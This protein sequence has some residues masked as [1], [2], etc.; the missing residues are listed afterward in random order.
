[1]A[2]LATAEGDSCIVENI[3]EDRFKMVSQLQKM[4]AL[5][6]VCQS[7]AK[8]RGN[9]LT[10]ARVEAQELRGGAALVLAGLAA[11]GETYVENR[12]FI[13]RGYEDICRDLS[14]M[15]ARILKD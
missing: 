10:G 9:S 11:R 12:H 13:E 15:G 4:G 1:M 8:I 6:E 3:F 14:H 7:K 5:I 2:V